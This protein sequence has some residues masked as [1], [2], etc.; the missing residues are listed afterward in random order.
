MRS[1][2]ERRGS[3]R[4]AADRR[5]A[6][7]RAVQ[8]PVALGEGERAQP[9]R[10]AFARV[11]QADRRRHDL[12]ASELIRQQA[13]QRLD[14]LAVQRRRH[15][16]LIE[17]GEALGGMLGIAAEQFVRTLAG[18]HHLHALRRLARNQ[19]DRDVGG[20][21]DR[22]VAVIDQGRQMLHQVVGGNDELGCD[23]CANCFAI[24]RGIV[25]FGISR[26]AEADREGVD[27]LAECR[28]HQGDDRSSCR[29]R[30]RERRRTARRSPC[31]CAPPRRALSRKSATGSAIGGPAS[32]GAS[33]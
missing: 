24:I 13:R 1:S 7:H 27:R 19:I 11:A 32:V 26:L 9:A 8:Q 17:R 20:L 31:G 29:S 22:R 21:G 33:P 16:P 6:R 10:H 30:P 15:D 18:Q 14:Q 23:A 2:A 5:A 4:K 25:Q 12:D 28:R 3:P